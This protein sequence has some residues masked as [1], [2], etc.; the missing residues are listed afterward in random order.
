MGK[1]FRRWLW[2]CLHKF[3]CVINH[4]L[5]GGKQPSWAAR[6]WYVY[7]PQPSLCQSR[8]L[9]SPSNRVGN[10]RN[11]MK[12]PKLLVR[13]CRVSRESTPSYFVDGPFVILSRCPINKSC[14]VLL[15]SSLKEKIDF[16]PKQ[17]RRWRIFSGWKWR[18]LVESVFAM[19]S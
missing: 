6:I 7:W 1:Q 17:S 12:S 11:P 13:F 2:L 9:A 19:L 16:F 5:F 14:S 8:S 10:P 3:A 18:W 15:A 4:L